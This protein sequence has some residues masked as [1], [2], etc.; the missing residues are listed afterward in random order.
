MLT[1]SCNG[2]NGTQNDLL[3][4]SSNCMNSGNSVNAV[5]DINDLNGVVLLSQNG[6][7]VANNGCNCGC[8]NNNNNTN[9]IAARVNIVPNSNDNGRTGYLSGCYRRRCN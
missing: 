4:I 8:N 9:P 5:N 3:T 7:Q 1:I 6:T 2:C